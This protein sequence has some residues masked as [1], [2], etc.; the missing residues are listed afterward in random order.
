MGITRYEKLLESMSEEDREKELNILRKYTYDDLLSDNEIS[1]LLNIPKTSIINVKRKYKINKTYE[2]TQKRMA[3]IN[4]EQYLNKESVKLTLNAFKQNENHPIA[5]QLLSE[6]S[7][8]EHI[9]LLSPN[10]IMEKLN[11]CRPLLSYIRK[12]YNIKRTPAEKKLKYQKT[13][14]NMPKEKYDNII[15]KRRITNANKSPEEK[16]QTKLKMQNTCLL[17]YGVKHNWQIA[18]IREK[19]NQ[20]NE[21]KYGTKN[22][23]YGFK[24]KQ[25]K[26]ERYGDEN[27]NNRE[28]YK[29]TYKKFSKEK[30]ETIRNKTQDTCM[31]RYGVKHHMQNKNI[32]TKLQQIFLNKYG[33]TNPMT[34]YHNESSISKTNL[35]FKNLL[36]TQLNINLELEFNILDKYYD[37]KYNNLL[38][39]L[40]PSVTHNSTIA[41]AHLCGLCAD[42]NCT[43]HK[44]LYKNYH[45]DK[46]LLAK[47]FGYELI[48]IFDWYDLDKIISLIKSKC[49]L[50]NH[51]IGARQTQIKL[52]DKQI[53]KEFFN[54]NHI[55]GYDN[56][57]SIAY[58]LYYNN[59]LVSAMSFGKPR[60][61][62]NYEWELLRF[63]NLSNYTVMGAASKLWKRFILEHN[64]K[65]VI[66]YTN[67]DFGNGEVY[68]NLGFCLKDII[69]NN[70]V[71]NIPYKNI[72]I[73]HTSLIKQGADRLLKNKINNYFPVGLDYEDF[74]KR[75][76]KKEYEKEYS[77]LP[78]DTDWWP[79]N[80][81]IMKHYGFV[82]IYNCGTSVYEYIKEK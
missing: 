48:S 18:E 30:L 21:K 67:N 40:N 78:D 58:G 77:L 73:K 16:L 49:Q 82:E 46:W 71:W 50:N 31:K 80:I 51:K 32:Q 72:F 74:I 76:G 45:Y 4:W 69:K 2:M 43:K 28:K 63:A 35:K 44:P 26:K 36:E 62:K 65:S 70:K 42:I 13:Y 14:E 23:L 3:K 25:T 24:A 15:E 57:N 75:G 7:Y 52:L 9:E 41:F 6:I 33:T 55:M 66:T 47:N 17:R 54:N 79:G 27:Y 61:S 39:E 64:P 53:T 22:A 19:V 8:L 5:I 20:N 1:V 34:L 68:L 29:E 59:I 12:K 10:Q 56:G 81:D 60:Y 37:F 11:L 38:I